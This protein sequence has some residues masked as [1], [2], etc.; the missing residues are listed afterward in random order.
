[1]KYLIK[2]NESIRSEYEK[3]SPDEYYR[4]NKNIYQNPH[5]DRVKKSLDF[6]LSKSDIGYFLDLGCGDGIVSKYLKSKGLSKF[7]GCDPHFADIYQQK[8]GKECLN[9]SFEDISKFG[10]NEKFDSIICSYSLHLCDKSYLNNL[11]YQLSIS[12]RNLIVISPSKYP[13]ISETY[14][15][16][17]EK[18]IIER[19]HVRIYKSKL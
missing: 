13:I 1:M 19:T 16:L 12:C 17:L 2:F 7:K 6:I 8:L 10:L 15:S 11:L 4:V 18:S 14:F 3:S 5:S 9:L